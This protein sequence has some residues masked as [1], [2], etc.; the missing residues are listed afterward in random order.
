MT[1][2]IEKSLSE[3]FHLM[4]D[5]LPEPVQLCHKTYRVVAVNP[6]GETFGRS[7][8]QV[9]AGRFARNRSQVRSSLR[10]YPRTHH[11]QVRPRG[12]MLTI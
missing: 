7:P 4:Y 11:R 5:G 2:Q 8:G 1:E 3:A 9:C 10:A 12:V 6:A